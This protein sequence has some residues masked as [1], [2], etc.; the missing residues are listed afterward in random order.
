MPNTGSSQ[1]SNPSSDEETQAER[2]IQ[3]GI[4]ENPNLTKAVP[5]GIQHLLAMF[6]STVA[7]PLIIARAIGLGASG[8]TLVLQMAL[9]VAGVATLVQVYKIGIVGARLP[10]VMGTSSIF[11][12]AL[13]SIGNRYGIAAIIGATILAA[14]TEILIGYF[15]DDIR[16]LF[17]PLVTGLVLMLIGL[18]LAPIAIDYAAGGSGAETY[19]S[20]KNWALA[21]LVLV[22]T[23]ILH[24]FFDRFAR[25]ASILFA[26][27][28]GYLVG[29]PLGLVDFSRVASAGWISIPVP[30]QFGVEFHLS[31][32]LIVAFAYVVTS[33]ETIGD[34]SGITEAVGR[35]PESSELQGGVIADGVMSLIAGLFNTFPNTSFSQN[36]GLINFTGV[37]SRYVVGICG[38]LLVILGL[39]PKVAAIVAAMPSS[40]LGGAAIILFGMILSSGLRIIANRATL[41]QRNLTI[42]AITLMLGVG[43]ETATPQTLSSFPEIVRTLFGS[44]LITGGIAAL[45]LNAVLPVNSTK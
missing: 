24:Q 37:A 43:V 13:I 40:V 26:V 12:A 7:L 38:G 19:G 45:V 30:L 36:V 34:I 31:A 42:I 35:E 25:S 3:Y 10:V 6:L 21:G 41:N 18:T 2:E 5:L 23:L 22:L 28:I 1:G 4:E 29:I 17:P 32:V 27:V 14:P 16:D 44:G 8:V 33:I 39:S 20:L 11:V 15:I 9:L